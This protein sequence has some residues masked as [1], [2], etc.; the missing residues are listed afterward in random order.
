MPFPS[1][2]T[3]WIEVRT[4]LEKHARANH[5]ILAPNEF[6]EFFPSNYP[7]EVTALLPVNHFAFV[8]FHK[9]MVGKI[10]PAFATHVIRQFYPVYAN[11]VFVIYASQALSDEMSPDQEHVQPLLEQLERE[12][13]ER[14]QQES[15]SGG[16][17]G[18][19]SSGKHSAIVVTTHDRSE[20]L[21]RS[22]PQLVVLAVPI[23][24]VDDGSSLE[25]AQE[26]Q[27][28]VDQYQIPLVYIPQ[29]RGLPNAINVGVGYWLADANIE[30]ISYF[31]DDIDIQPDILTVL[32]QIQDA[33]TRPLL[34]GF[35]ATE[36]PVFAVEEIAGCEVLLKRSTSGQHLH[37]HRN[38]WSQVLP[39]PTP[40]L[41]VASLSEG[42]GADVDWWVVSWAPQSIVKRGGY[43][44]CV[45]GLVHSLRSPTPVPPVLPPVSLSVPATVK[46]AVESQ[47]AVESTVPEIVLPPGIS[48]AQ[49]KVL[50]DGY[51]LQLTSGTGIKT[52]GT[53]LVK[54]LHLLEAKVD[55][56]FSRGGFKNNKILD[57]VFFFDNQNQKS[58]LIQDFITIAKGLVKTSVGSLYPAKRRQDLG[59]YVVKQ[60]KYSEDFLEYAKSFNLPQCYATANTVYKYLNLTTQIHLAEPVDIWHATYP[61]PI[62]VSGAKKITTIHDLIP[63]RLPYATLDNKEYFYN[64]VRDALK[65]SAVTIA[66]SEHSKQDL[67]A[68]FDVDPDQI[69]VTYQ[70]IALE[71]LEADISEVNDFLKRYRL[72][73][74]KY[75]L[76]VGA[77]EPKKNLGR[78]VDAYSMIDTDLPLVIVG[79]KGWLWEDELG[80]AQSLFDK[81]SIQQVKLL[82]YVTAN[83][84]RYLY[85]GAYC[86][87]FPSL[88]EGFGLPPIEA[89]NFGCPVIT[90]QAS[91][92][93]EICGEAALYVDPY[94][95][96]DI[97]QKLETLL[98]DSVLRDRL[99]SAGKT[100]AERFSIENYVKRLYW[101]YARALE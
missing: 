97:Q 90:S 65:D 50:V 18:G 22:L 58:D 99:I 73:A 21:A 98:S 60:G 49:V 47:A 41:G 29:N 80:K 82:E 16:N 88:Y 51:N 61:L 57:E 36:H 4:F 53:S 10:S 5:P 86:L 66:V 45:P 96:I 75:I 34:S 24:V 7:Y 9:D 67:L 42:Q 56:L 19:N 40:Y 6:L 12:Q 92:L 69:V 72:E 13:L 78:L 95:V 74:G 27:R 54:A 8:V 79:K 84:L 39:I 23:V 3:Y 87:V 89:M 14:E 59:E 71:P 20:A 33:E 100:N 2:D 43:V 44:V 48:L 28:I 46:A 26:N 68:Y 30:W 85:R 77:I 76:F 25:S 94:D 1:E 15:D 101:A 17:S 81:D 93:P 11:A 63:L 64:N 55:V 83:A 35:N 38:Y 70:P 91:C 31:Q 52:Y 62:K 32:S 37:A